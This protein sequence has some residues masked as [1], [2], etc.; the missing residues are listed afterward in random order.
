MTA[1]TRRIAAL[2]AG[3]AAWGVALGRL[4]RDAGGGGA[5]RAVSA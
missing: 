2:L 1:R 4:W 3:L 5:R